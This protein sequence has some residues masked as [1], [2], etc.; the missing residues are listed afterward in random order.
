VHLTDMHVTDEKG[1]AEA[2]GKALAS[3]NDIHPAPQFM[4]TGGDHIRDGLKQTRAR[5]IEQWDVY[6]DVL[7]QH[8]TP[9]SF[10]VIGNHDVWGW[11]AKESY[12]GQLGFGKTIAFQRLGLTQSYYSFDVGGWH[13]IVLDS[14]QRCPGNYFGGLDAAQ[15]EWL[16]RDLAA[17][18]A[19]Q[20]SRNV[21]VITHIPVISIC[22]MFFCYENCEF[23]SVDYRL[24]NNLIHLDPK[25]LLK[26]L[27]A[28]DVK[29]AISGHIHLLEKFEYMGIHFVCDGSICGSW[30]NGP[31]QEV[32]EGYGVFDLYPDGTFEHQYITYGWVAAK[33]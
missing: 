13:F 16:H 2:Y 21:C 17:N 7:R 25:P 1:A 19:K 12:E 32:P 14:I 28:F 29:L 5:V 18:A 9:Q 3:L 23:P 15:F 8:S 27:A 24:V 6:Q 26:L 30:W 33:S 20:P 22:A 4:V 11:S 31:F 10:P